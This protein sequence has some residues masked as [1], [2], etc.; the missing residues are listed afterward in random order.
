M[1]RLRN[2]K[3]RQLILEVLRSTY[4]HPT[5]DWLYQQVREQ[6]PNISL[7][8]VYRNL[9]L[10][11]EQGV[12]QEL[13]YAGQQNRYD[14]NPMP[15]YHLTCDSCHQVMDVDIPVQS[16]LE[17]KLR[18]AM[19]ELDVSG[20]NLEFYGTCPECAGDSGENE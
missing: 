18:N 2:T 6:M 12:I 14:G 19:P 20:H 7:G 9:N 3:Q 11:R 4:S 16:Q 10:L 17:E 15:H 5:V 8:T 13:R 1:P